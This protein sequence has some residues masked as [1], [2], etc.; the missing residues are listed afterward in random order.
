MK[1]YDVTLYLIRN[2]S[3]KETLQKIADETKLPLGWL[4]SFSRG[5][6]NE[7]SVNRVQV[8]YEYLSKKPLL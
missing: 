5:K 3:V 6:C 1:L 8:L 2:R 4:K 7:P